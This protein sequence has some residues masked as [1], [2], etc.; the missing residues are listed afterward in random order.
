MGSRLPMV[1]DGNLVCV[2]DGSYMKKRAKNV[3]S[4]GWIL[5]CRVTK[6]QIGGTFVEISP[7]ADSYRGELLGMLAILTLYLAVS[8]GSGR[9]LRGSYG[10]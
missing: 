1:R 10:G 7:S 9:V 2:T 5:A 3:C 4:A 8:T 6:R